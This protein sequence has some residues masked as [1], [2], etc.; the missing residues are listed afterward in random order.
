MTSCCAIGR[1]ILDSIAGCKSL[2]HRCFLRISHIRQHLRVSRIEQKIR[3][4]GRAA[5]RGSCKCVAAKVESLEKT[6]ENLDAAI[7]EIER[8]LK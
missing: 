5:V 6:R 2:I 3:E 4:L 8:V 7:V 1:P